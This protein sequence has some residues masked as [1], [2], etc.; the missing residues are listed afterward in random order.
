[1]INVLANDTDA[2]NDPLTVTAVTQ[3]T[4][5]SVVNNGDGTVSYT[6]EPNYHGSDSFT[7]TVSDPTGSSIGTVNVT[8]TS[9]NDVP[10]A[11]NDS[12]TTDEDTPVTVSVLDNDTDVDGDTLTVSAVTQGANGSVA[13][14]G[15]TV[16]YTP[17]PNFHGTDSFTYTVSD[18]NGGTATATVT[19]TVNSVNDVPNAVDD[20]ANTSEDTP[21]IINVLANDTDADGDTLTITGTTNPANGTIVNNGDGTITYTPNADFFGT[22]SFTYTIGDSNGGSDTATVTVNVGAVDDAPIAN[23]DSATTDEDTPVVIDV[24]ANDTDTEGDTLSV[25]AVTNGAHGTVANNGTNVTYTPN[26]NFFGTDSF[27]YTASDGNG[28]SDTATVTVTVNS[29]N[30][31]PNAADDGFSTPESTTLTVP[32]PGVLANDTDVEG[33]ALTAALATGVSNGTLNFNA[34]GS[35]TY[36]P[37]AGFIG[38]DSFTYTVSD[39]SLSDTAT[40]TIT[41]AENA[42]PVAHDDTYSTLPETTLDVPAPGVLGND[43]DAEGQSLTAVLVATTT[44]GTLTL[45]PDGSFTYVPDAGFIGADSF[46]YQANDGIPET[47]P[48]GGMRPLDLSNV[49]TVTINVGAVATAVPYWPS[50]TPL[51]PFAD[52]EYLDD[53]VRSSVPDQFRNTVFGRLIVRNGSLLPGLDYG[54]IGN[55]ELVQMGIITAIDIYSTIGQKNFG[56]GIGICIKGQGRLFFLDANF[57]PRSPRELDWTYVNG[58]TCGTIL[59]PGIVVLV[60]GGGAASQASASQTVTGQTCDVTMRAMVHLRATPT[61]DSESLTIVPVGTTLRT[62]SRTGDWYAVTYAGVSGYVSARWAVP[63]G[64]C[65]L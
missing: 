2:E 53:A 29:V 35:F 60:Q 47:A 20:V 64:T 40:V 50:P 16:T 7:Y 54:Y 31:A 10:N 17:N 65:G 41:I 11:V 24:L 52:Y 38:A 22:D 62:S 12:A 63:D 18:G 27:T 1:M 55:Q 25:G 15:A 58:Y 59:D 48:A 23:D 32:A 36:V 21:V 14:N 30:D 19:I 3:G 43:T 34:D 44:H 33:D 8:V 39:G 13:N 28:G 9:V 4:H 45:N 37:D 6:P 61:T 49:A 51:S 26:A 56:V 57:A 42:A 46:S 5:G